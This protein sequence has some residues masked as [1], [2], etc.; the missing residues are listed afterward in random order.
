MARYPSYRRQK[1]RWGYY[2]LVVIIIAV[3]VV[4][5][6]FSGKG[7]AVSEGEGGLGDERQVLPESGADDVY[8]E[9]L[10]E[11]EVVRSSGG[12]E[13]IGDETELAE[14]PNGHVAKLI[15]EAVALI[16]AS[17][18]RIIDARDSL[19]EILSMPMSV[20]QQLFVKERLSELSEKWLFSPTIFPQ[21]NLC[22]SLRVRAGDQLSTIGK[23]HQVPYEIL[24]KIN[25]L[26][27]PEALR[28]GEQIKVAN[29]P[30]HVKIY[31]ST[32]MMDLY[33]QNT[34]V[35]SLPVGLAKAGKQTPTGF[36]RVKTGGK[37][38]EPIWTDP[39]TGQ[40]FGPGD[41]NYPLGSVWI[42]ME[43]I[44]GEAVGQSSFG[45]HGTNEPSSIGTASSRGCIRL[46]NGD[47]K[48]IYNVLV[49]QHSRILVVD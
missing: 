19:N 36:W 27:R 29:G 32:F 24:M 3:L 18:A 6:L 12:F 1:N 37:L 48:L 39:D 10:E 9:T 38:R 21:D 47:A 2:V 46:H 31:R 30:F 42:A 15:D 26:S 45:I 11:P 8:R 7:D 33:L 16:N 49:P 40:V 44:S 35:L 4:I 17:P 41:P 34:F 25:N 20:Q 13:L 22:S 23:N 5:F 14:E 28:A 43:G